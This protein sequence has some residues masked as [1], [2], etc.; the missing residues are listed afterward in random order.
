MCLLIPVRQ[1]EG[2]LTLNGI[3]K[4]FHAFIISFKSDIV[5]LVGGE[6]SVSWGFHTLILRDA[7]SDQPADV[8]R[9][10]QR[11][12][13]YEAECNIQVEN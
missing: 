8:H 10:G 6:T 4:L 2:Y 7:E 9:T 5:A 3:I 13:I 12:F 11:D 1:H